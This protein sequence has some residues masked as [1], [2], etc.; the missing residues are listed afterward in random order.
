MKLKNRTLA[1]TFFLSLPFMMTSAYVQ[2]IP[3]VINNTDYDIECTLQS[4]STAAEDYIDCP[5]N[6]K[7]EIL[8]KIDQEDNK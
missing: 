6:G 5:E 8:T 7:I 3:K 2:G 1:Y 4:Y